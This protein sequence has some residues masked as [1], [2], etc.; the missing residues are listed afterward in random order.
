MVFI[1]SQMKMFRCFFILLIL[2]LSYTNEA[3]SIELM[4]IIIDPGH[5]GSDKGGEGRDGILE[6]DI[7]LQISMSLKKKI[8]DKIKLNIV[9]TRDKDYDV[10]L[11]KRVAIAN[12]GNGDLFISIH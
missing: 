1:I 2:L 11:E 8:A 9:V 4:T 3:D 6:K 5:G 7:T 10:P 12:A